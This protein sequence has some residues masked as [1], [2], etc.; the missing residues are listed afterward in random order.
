M[1]ELEQLRDLLLGRDFRDLEQLQ[2]RIGDRA[3]L[4]RDVAEVLPEAIVAG[5]QDGGR[6]AD[7][8]LDS[9]GDPIR[10]SIERDRRGLAEALVPVMGPAVRGAVGEALTSLVRSINQAVAH[11]L[12]LRAL[13]WRW[14][15]MRS[16]VPFAA[17]VLKHTLVYRVD[18][19]YLIHNDSGLL[20]A[21]VVA[22]TQTTLKD[23]AAVSGMLT[24]I[25]HFVEESFA[26]L[27]SGG[28]KT[29]EIGERTLWL[30]KGPEASLTCVISGVPPADLRQR[31]EALLTEIH[32]AY[33]SGLAAFRGNN[34]VVAG[35]EDLLERALLLQ[36]REGENAPAVRPRLWPW[37]L[38]LGLTVGWLGWSGWQQQ[39]QE[40]RMELLLQRLDSEPGIVVLDWRSR[41]RGYEVSLLRDPLAVD[42][43]QLVE[44]ARLGM[45]VR[46]S[47]TPFQSLD[48]PLV[49]E[50]ARRL[51][52]VPEGVALRLEGGTLFALGKAPLEWL[53]RARGLM[54]LPP[55]VDVLDLS[56][57]AP[58]LSALP[59]A[60][61]GLPV[62][63]GVEAALVA[64]N[65]NGPRLAAGSPPTPLIA[66]CASCAFQS[67]LPL[68]G[69]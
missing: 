35:V 40:R 7:A 44:A 32:R 34:R 9:L 53:A 29:V 47:A 67:A 62:L 15:A 43:E 25:E 65:R 10:R 2:S 59:G 56:G 42:P 57:V 12:S 49:L 21:H 50:R 14:E 52:Q 20:V 60:I 38:A 23:E 17:V 4:V 54:I 5:N 8:L 26:G 18:A 37:V 36:Y 68:C 11:T 13:R 58:T 66:D 64:M 3:Q 19:A 27:G 30:I 1:K 24:A 39:A 61:E 6:V 33:G 69:R 46:V 45:A 16:G 48:P 63:R 41:E 22:A 31:L 55:G 28:L 51:L